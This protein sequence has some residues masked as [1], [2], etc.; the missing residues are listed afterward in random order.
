ML[1][2]F[3]FGVVKTVQLWGIDAMKSAIGFPRHG[4]AQVDVQSDSVAI[5]D[6]DDFG[7][8]VIQQIAHS[9][10]ILVMDDA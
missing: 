7:F 9:D 3:P 10:G 6:S 1:G 8:V 2:Y 4:K 5:H